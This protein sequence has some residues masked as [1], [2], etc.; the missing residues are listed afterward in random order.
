MTQSAVAAQ[1]PSVAWRVVGVFSGLLSGLAWLLVFG[2]L[3][4]IVPKFQ[5]IFQ[6]FDAALPLLTQAVISAAQVVSQGWPVF[7]A[8]AFG[9][10]AAA[11]LLSILARSSA[12]VT[13]AAVLGLVSV[14]MFVV[15]MAA[16]VI[17]LFPPM[18]SLV[19]VL[20]AKS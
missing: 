2:V 1:R 10:P 20:G 6:R 17:G 19:E 11:I 4:F 5:E 14:F 12:G 15:A 13:A 16:I 3:V 7:A 8:L 18:M 9:V